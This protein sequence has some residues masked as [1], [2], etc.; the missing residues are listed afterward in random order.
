M[1]SCGA[2]RTVGASFQGWFDQR[3]EL[4]IWLNK[5]LRQVRQMQKTP[6]KSNSARYT[7]PNLNET[8]SKKGTQPT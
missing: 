7:L 4:W 5:P 3:F 2:L 8:S 6:I 1:E